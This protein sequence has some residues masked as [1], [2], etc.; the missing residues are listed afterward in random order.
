MK[1]LQILA[2]LVASLLAYSA[3]ALV[4]SVDS[5]IG[6]GFDRAVPGSFDGAALDG[7]TADTFGTDIFQN[8]GGNNAGRHIYKV[9]H[10]NEA[11]ANF[12][13]NSTLYQEFTFTVASIGDNP[14]SGGS[15]TSGT[16]RYRMYRSNPGSAT[17]Y[18]YKPWT[19]LTVGSHTTSLNAQATNDRQVGIQFEGS[20]IT[21]TSFAHTYGT[22]TDTIS[23]QAVPEPST[24]AL[25]AGFAAFLF[26]AIKRRK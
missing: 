9:G 14:F 26:V 20:G 3:S 24:Y 1:T 19:N 15:N 11:N 16:P 6:G 2:V 21:F 17:N 22:T 4:I 5:T 10:F 7:N 13:A 23:V 25:L 12:W 8:A 18:Y